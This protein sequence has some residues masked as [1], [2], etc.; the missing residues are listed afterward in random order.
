V[1]GNSK[2]LLFNPK[3]QRSCH[4]Q[5]RHDS[6]GAAQ[7]MSENDEQ[8]KYFTRIVEKYQVENFAAPATRFKYFVA[9]AQKMRLGWHIFWLSFCGFG[10]C[11]QG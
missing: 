8:K 9:S 10:F 4:A 7:L 11:S 2:L 3:N 1:H 5:N 6:D